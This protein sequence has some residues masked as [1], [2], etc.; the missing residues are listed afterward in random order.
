MDRL[1]SLLLSQWGSEDDDTV[2]DL[3]EYVEWFDRAFCS[4]VSFLIRI[5][6]F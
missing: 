5:I 3:G 4:L 2:E 6:R 1:N